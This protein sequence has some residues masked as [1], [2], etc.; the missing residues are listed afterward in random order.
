MSWHHNAEKVL[1]ILFKAKGDKDG[2]VVMNE[3]L[4]EEGLTHPGDI[5]FAFHWLADRERRWVESDPPHAM[6]EL[7]IWGP[8]KRI[9]SLE[10]T[11]IKARLTQFGQDEKVRRKRPS[12]MPA[13]LRGIGG[14]LVG[15]AAIVGLYFNYF[16]PATST[17]PTPKLQESTSS[18][19][20]QPSSSVPQNHAAPSTSA[21]SV[22]TM[23]H[24]TDSVRPN[25]SSSHA[26]FKK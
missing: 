13:W 2:W 19:T 10:N 17:P 20:A 21:D 9:M 11:T 7:S 15:I 14:V 1:A 16:A 24:G 4:K 8:H 18:Q 23:S 22:P 3:K 25:S 12:Q 6:M 5:K 26:P